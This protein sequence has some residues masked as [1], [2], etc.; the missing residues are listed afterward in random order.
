[1]SSVLTIQDLMFLTNGPYSLELSLGECCG[2]NGVSGVG[3]SQFLR[4]VADV[5]PHQGECKLNTISSISMSPMDW[6]KRVALVP[7]ES[8]WWYDTVEPHFEEAN[9]NNA[10]LCHLIERLGFS[11]DV[12]HWQISRLSTGERQRLSLIRT[13]IQNPEVLLLDEPTSGLDKTMAAVVETIVAER[14]AQKES[15]C[16][17]VSHDL[18]QLA[19]I[20]NRCFQL[21]Q[22]ALQEI[23]L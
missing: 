6:R 7:A 9:Q 5:L 8:F 22:N 15:S 12:L 2:L 13:L 11:L 16:L 3:K 14:C 19:R 20:S 4:A 18:E 21:E 17:W 10:V 1:M 23:T